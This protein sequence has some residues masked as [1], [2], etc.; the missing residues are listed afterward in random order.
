MSQLLSPYWQRSKINVAIIAACVATPLSTIVSINASAQVTTT[1]KEQQEKLQPL[2]RLDKPDV[3]GLW[4]HINEKQTVLANQEL[5]RLKYEFPNWVVPDDIQQAI[6]TLNA[7]SAAQSTPEPVIAT[8]PAPD[9]VS[10]PTQEPSKEPSKDAPLRRLASQSQSQRAGITQNHFNRLSRLADSLERY[11]YHM[12]LGWTAIDKSLLPEAKH[13]FARADRL[14][15]TVIEKKGAVEGLQAVIN[16]RIELALKE[17]ISIGGGDGSSDGSSDGTRNTKLLA[18][19][20]EA[21]TDASQLAQV[22]AALSGAAWEQYDKEQYDKALN[23]FTLLDDSEGMWLSLHAQGLTTEAA[24]FACDRADSQVFLTRCADFLAT[25]QVRYYEESAFAKSVEA[26]LSLKSIRRLRVG[27]QALLGWAASKSLDASQHH[28]DIAKAAFSETLKAQP[29]NQDIANALINLEEDNS[30]QLK[31]LA[32]E[33]PLIAL[34]QQRKLVTNAWPRKQFILAFNNNDSRATEAQT[35]D[36][37]TAVA[38][39]T[40]RSRSGQEGLGNFDELIS[41]VGVGG[42]VADWRWQ[43]A[44]DYK[45]LYSGKPAEGSWFANGE[46]TSSFL[47]ISGFED[48]EMRAE[49]EYQQEAFNFYANAEYS[50]FD[51]PENATLTGQISATWFLPKVTLA[52]T[53]FRLPKQDSLLSQTGTLNS[54]HTDSWGYVL[55]D[56]VSVLAAHSFRPQWSIAG[57]FSW[58]K[59]SGERVDENQSLSLR[60]DIGYD[61][62]PIVSERLDYWRV[63]HFA[64]YLG[65]EKNLSG[66]TYGNGG[67]FSPDY[68]VSIG[69]YSELLTMEAHRWQFKLSA[70]LGL[71]I[72]QESDDLRFPLLSTTDPSYADVGDKRLPYNSS[73]GLSG[74]AMFEGQYRLSEQWIVAGYIG[75]AFAVEYQSFEAGVQIRWRPGKGIGVTSDELM[76]SSPRLSGFA[77]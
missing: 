17:G 56:G 27:E 48:K 69:G 71:S 64:S 8:Q 18:L 5:G 26:G 65:Y 41:Y 2:A 16:S 68:L 4:Y 39:L 55:A 40:T 20:Q 24:E 76:R 7:P 47:G 1:Y 53:L 44:L 34:I 22:K 61:L 3:T 52:T 35:K 29:D 32:N 21:S 6:K 38:G 59:L 57:T 54:E 43:V 30:A 19:L 77:L 70:S 10:L 75:K 66:F 50:L 72:L 12:L 74:N 60:A 13:H 36:A 73:T 23:L 58:A 46:T 25:E 9:E 15:T 51:Q 33:F 37:Y 28:A 31:Q 62:A 67:Y 45:Q 14:H 49:V 63:G 42:M 11:D